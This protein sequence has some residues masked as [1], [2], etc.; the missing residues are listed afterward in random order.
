MS[1]RS[2]K[3]EAGSRKVLVRALAGVLLIGGM[4]VAVFGQGNASGQVSAPATATTE[5][6]NPRLPDGGQNVRP[7]KDNGPAIASAPTNE[8]RGSLFEA[9]ASSPV[10]VNA[11]GEPMESAP[12]SF[13][14]V[15]PPHAK[16]FRKNDLVTII[17]Q[18]DSAYSSN[19]QTQSQK[20]QDFD[21]ALQNWFQLHTSANGVPKTMGVGSSG[22]LP[23][24]KFKYDNNRQNQAT[25]DRTDSLSLR[26]AAT[27]V[28]VKP[29]GTMVLEAGKDITVDREVQHFHMSGLCRAEDVTPDNTLLSSQLAN[30]TV[31][32]KTSGEVRDGTKSGW[33]NTIIDK[34]NP[35]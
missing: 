6:T 32:K 7:H 3:S 28:D 21:L 1:T 4:G 29:N 27:V 25:N 5:D 26:I 12:V 33:L 23:E 35:F 13:M 19:A 11:E 18:E 30:L 34:V 15:A 14:A 24:A 17:V 2:Q 20:Q 31:S 10:P 9:A 22:T 8:I 16:K